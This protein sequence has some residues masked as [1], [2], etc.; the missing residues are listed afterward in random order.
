MVVTTFLMASLIPRSVLGMK[1]GCGL[2]DKML[3][4]ALD[5]HHDKQ[6]VGSAA[7]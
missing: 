3:I 5:I 6:L 4:V 2:E 7:V 1:L